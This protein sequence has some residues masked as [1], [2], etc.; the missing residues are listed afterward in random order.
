[1]RASSSRYQPRHAKPARNSWG[2][3]RDDNRSLPNHESAP[4]RFWRHHRTWIA[5]CLVALL[6]GFLRF[7][8][9]DEPHAV[10]F[11]ETYY[12]KDAW[13]MLMTGEPRNWPESIAAPGGD[14]TP[15]Q[16]FAQG[17]TNQWLPSAEYVVHPPVGK[18][19]IALGLKLFGG[20]S[21]PF[22]WR[23]AVAIAGTIAIVLLMRV[24]LR[25]FHN[26]SVAVLAGV[27]MSIDGVGITLSRTGLLDNFIMV[28]ALGA[29]A[30]LLLHR[31]R[32]RRL[33]MRASM[34]PSANASASPKPP[35]LWFSRYRV[36]AAVL[37]G[38]ATGVKWSGIYFLAAFCVLTVVWDALLVRE[39]GYGRWFANG[40]VQALLTACYMVP[41]WFATY[42]AGWTSWFMH[43]DS[44]MHNWAAT[45]PGEGVTW[46]P[47]GL[48]SFVQYHAQMWRFH[49]TL[50][51]WHPYK[52]NPLT[53]P[54]QIRPTSFYWEKLAGHP[55]LC[56]LSP[57]SQCVA[58]VTSLGNPLIWWLAS[59]CVILGII[60]AIIKR[61]DWR[62]WA[63]LIGLIG[64]WLPWAQYI[65]RTTFTFYSVVI[66]PWMI[67]AICY[68][69]NE[70]RRAADRALWN[71]TLAC[72]IIVCSAV[73]VFFYPIWTA[74][75]VPYHFW[76]S[77]MWLQSWI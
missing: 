65:H 43:S 12:V 39:F 34:L 77:H 13:T 22:A 40:F 54:L 7:F 59:L 52:A 72:L 29:F 32:S 42:V 14:L 26:L 45:H 19:F 64:G 75:P 11:D 57:D 53:W 48:R 15:D 46:L 37:L 10:I 61:G 58:A 55:G 28:L 60:I 25:L 69:F 27:L 4:T 66:L 41:I 17:D 20:A 8:R 67:L 21:N 49:T 23:A 47:E 30:L 35:R 2:H 51:S 1:M 63:V 73:S 16:L 5:T 50:D 71:T 44:Y 70:I 3:A 18:W 76:L 56:A 6:G 9:L 36:G 62:I 33:L 68:V 74:M 24:T 38:L 31:D